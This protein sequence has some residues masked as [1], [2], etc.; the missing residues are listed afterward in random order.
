MC[1]EFCSK[2]REK[3]QSAFHIC[4]AQDSRSVLPF[5]VRCHKCL[6]RWLPWCSTPVSKIY[7]VILS[8]SFLQMWTPG[9][10]WT[11][12]QAA[13][14]PGCAASQHSLAGPCYGFFEVG[15]RNSHPQFW[16]LTNF[17]S[18]GIWGSGVHPG[19]GCINKPEIT[20][21]SDCDIISIYYRRK[22]LAHVS[23]KVWPLPARGSWPR[24]GCCP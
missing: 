22:E 10:V 19:K 17:P 18:V 7:G 8:L 24:P 20:W 12:W 1:Q 3:G 21:C 16:F 14:S 4:L 11:F 6:E 23:I 13:R 2:T 9:V 5:D 15:P